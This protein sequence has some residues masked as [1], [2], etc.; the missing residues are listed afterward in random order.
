MIDQAG[1]DPVLVDVM[2]HGTTV[3][4]NALIERKAVKV[5]LIT[6]KGLRDSLAIARGNR[7]DFSTGSTKSPNPLSP[8]ICAGNCRNG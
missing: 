7:P 8:G 3:V 6:T 5:G 4:I 1:I 2:V